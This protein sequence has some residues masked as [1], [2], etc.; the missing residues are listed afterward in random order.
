M[1][2]FL[3]K[4][5][6]AL[7]VEDMPA[8]SEDD[9]AVSLSRR[10]QSSW[11]E[12]VADAQA[13]RR[14]PSLLTAMNRT[15]FSAYMLRASVLLVQSAAKISMTQALGS[16]V[17][18][19]DSPSDVSTGLLFAAWLVV[20]AA[21]SGAIHH[22]YF[23]MGWRLGMQ[24]RIAT[25]SLVFAKSLEVSAELQT[26]P[27]EEAEEAEVSGQTTPDGTGPAPAADATQP[28]SPGAEKPLVGKGG[29]GAPAE[30]AKPM[31]ADVN[32]LVG[33]DIERFQKIGQFAAFV[34][35]GPLESIVVCYF[36]WREL[37]AASLA[38]VGMLLCLFA[39]QTSFSRRFGQLR[40]AGAHASDERV[41]LVSQIV[42]GIRGIKENSWE[43]P[44][45]KRVQARR[46]AEVA[47]VRQAVLLK[48]VNEALFLV[49]PVLIGGA[50]Y[51]T[52]HLTGGTLSPRIVFTTLALVAVLQ[53]MVTK[54][55]PMAAEA[56]AECF[57]S[58]RRIQEFL[59]RPAACNISGDETLFR[60]VPVGAGESAPPAPVAAGG[61]PEAEDV[62][63]QLQGASAKW[64]A[65]VG[66][67][68]VPAPHTA[69]D[70]SG[71]FG[72]SDLSLSVSR[73]GLHFVAG[74]VGAGKTSLL[75][76]LLGELPL[77]SGRL[78]LRGGLAFSPQSAWIITGSF[79][80]NVQLDVEDAALYEQVLDMCC[81][82]PDLK[83][84]DG[85]DATLLGE[86]GVNLS[87]GQLARLSLA[88]AVYAAL[89]RR[90]AGEDV[91]LL[92]DDPLAAVD[93]KVARELFHGC[94]LQLARQHGVGVLLVTHQLQ[95][96]H[97]ADQVTI[98]SAG[99]VLLTAPPGKVI[100]AAARPD[101]GPD[102]VSVG[103]RIQGEEG[104]GDGLTVDE[105]VMQAAAESA[106]GQSVVTQPSTAS[107]G[108]EAGAGDAS[109]PVQL[110][111]AEGSGAGTVGLSTYTTYFRAAG[112]W[113]VLVYL[114]GFIAVAQAIMFL[115]QWWLAEWAAQSA[116]EQQRDV[117][118][119]TFVALVA[120]TFLLAVV[121][122]ALFFFACLASASSLHNSAFGN[123]LRAPQW[124]FDANPSGRILNRLSKD[125]G[126]LD[127]LLPVTFH[128]T[129]TL[130]TVVIGAIIIS[131][132]ANPFT[133]L[134][135]L[136]LVWTFRVTRAYFL[137]SAREVK[138]REAITRSPM[139]AMLAEVAA[140]LP[141]IR[142]FR[143]QQSLLQRFSA[144]ANVNTTYY[145]WFLAASRWLGFYLS[146]VTITMLAGTAFLSVMAS[147]TGMLP[148]DPATIGLSLVYVMSMIDGLQWAVRQSAETENL[149]VSV[150]RLLEYARA[151]PT[152]PLPAPDS[153]LALTCGGWAGEACCAAS[154]VLAAPADPHADSA[155]VTRD[156]PPTWPAS[157]A[158]HF[159]Q[160]WLRYRHDL[161]WV[162]QGVDVALPSGSRVG[163]VGRTG[164]GKSSLVASILR[165]VAPATPDEIPD[166]AR[167]EG[168]E[169]CG[170][171][172]DGR[173]TR[174][175]PLAQLRA[176]IS[177]I[178]QDPILFANT[179]LRR[180]LDP[181]AQH[182]DERLW[183]ALAA[184]HLDDDVRARGGLGVPVAN[185]GGNFSVGQ[186]QLLC[187]ARATLRDTRVALLDEPTA[188]VDADTDAKIQLAI[189]EAFPGAT[190][191]TVAHRLETVIDCDVVV[192]MGAGKVLEAGRPA[193]LLAN[194]GGAF[195][196]MLAQ[197]GSEAAARLADRAAEAAAAAA[198]QMPS[199]PR[200]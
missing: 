90:Q 43:G 193:E 147:A 55:L 119:I 153:G 126:V 173:N 140:G 162:L 72:L 107:A 65:S 2:P 199:S 165:L 85:G 192:V 40:S 131:V 135:V 23:F 200:D 91:T 71:A 110:V 143:L 28:G 108:E 104:G 13:S 137:D 197:M 7:D 123:V 66:S 68:S 81:L 89:V 136:P 138:R 142:A 96:A 26:A 98:L 59:L 146:C 127:D 73:G 190:V 74:R 5:G 57:I 134:V 61:A 185:G 34:V 105:V 160:L 109:A 188:A 16:L 114:G 75:S 39:L 88:R 184:V 172:L 106:G 27:A 159:K 129:V 54:F 33:T 4:R 189:R 51:V 80:Y 84:L 11:R 128:D 149:L 69:V 8:F 141:V 97:H 38:A 170:V 166:Q 22:N 70:T 77:R 163:V 25:T 44:F 87:G 14:Q 183:Q 144:L 177:V 20:S 130:I 101:A 152:E 112:G 116:V 24:L 6:K 86:R 194:E 9:E 176:S 145:F 198:E 178:P 167:H 150:E 79:K 10:L 175:V 94:L 93:T 121:R 41:K 118:L 36:L 67:T 78:L 15:F 100:E 191:I 186:R 151:V 45:A 30:G 37:G 171:V 158:L 64:G 124:W 155:L 56:V 31:A 99:R 157:G 82:R 125:V 12:E 156:V 179:S 133:A 195:A 122:S 168:S 180:N 42:N 50:A 187:L 115:A 76:M 3:T 47:I 120:G 132:I 60:D 29:A 111:H 102:L 53:L 83:L 62:L 17:A 169:D 32:N 103:Q 58:V 95:F 92:V 182:S 19:L 35:T 49:A 174:T 139:F 196:G 161:P 154:S 117:W 18:W 113:F 164:A 52:F 46:R 1:F 181:F 63:V 148:L 21:M 48:A